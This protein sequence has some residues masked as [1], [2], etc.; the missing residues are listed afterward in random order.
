MAQVVDRFTVS[1][2]TEL[3]AAFDTH[4]AQR[5]YENRSEAVRDLIRDLLL[6]PRIRGNGQVIGFISFL[7]DHSRGAAGEQVRGMLAECGVAIRGI[8]TVPLDANT[9]AV[10]IALQAP[11]DEIG[12]TAD[13]IQTLRGVSYVNT[14][15]MPRESD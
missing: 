6:K 1:L 9:E 4:I 7:C 12:G 15:I 11:A 8:M 3:L 2:D 10:A 14:A 5:G 13:A